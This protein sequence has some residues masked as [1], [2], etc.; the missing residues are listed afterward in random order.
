MFVNRPA[1]SA[2]VWGRSVAAW[3]II[4]RQSSSKSRAMS[5]RSS[6]MVGRFGVWCV[7]ASLRTTVTT[8]TPHG[9]HPYF[10]IPFRLANGLDKAWKTLRSQPWL[11]R[12]GADV[13][14]A[15]GAPGLRVARRPVVRSMR[16]R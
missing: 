2:A 11:S 1:T 15:T 12:A 7:A 8:S 9:G 14:D 13:L 3:A 4:S 10:S 16:M 6:A 5:L